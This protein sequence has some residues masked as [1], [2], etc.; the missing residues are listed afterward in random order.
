MGSA[1][2]VQCREAL[3]EQLRVLADVVRPMDADAATSLDALT[4]SPNLSTDV[5]ISNV[6]NCLVAE[7]T[8][9]SSSPRKRKTPTIDAARKRRKRKAV[10]TPREEVLSKHFSSFSLSENKIYRLVLLAKKWESQRAPILQFVECEAPR[11]KEDHS[12][13]WGGFTHPAITSTTAT[14]VNHLI[15]EIEELET[16]TPVRRRLFLVVVNELVES[17]ISILREKRDQLRKIEEELCEPQEGDEYRALSERV[18]ELQYQL[19]P[20]EGQALRTGVIQ[21]LQRGLWDIELSAEDRKKK[22]TKFADCVRW[23]KKYSQLHPMG[24]IFFL[25]DMHERTE[26]SDQEYQAVTSYWM[27]LTSIYELC[28]SY[29]PLAHTLKQG[30]WDSATNAAVANGASDHTETLPIQLRA[31]AG[32]PCHANTSPDADTAIEI[33][34]TVARTPQESY[35]AQNSAESGLQLAIHLTGQANS[36]PPRPQAPTIRGLNEN[37]TFSFPQHQEGNSQVQELNAGNQ[38]MNSQSSEVQASGSEP[39]QLPESDADIYDMI[40]HMLEAQASGSERVLFPERDSNTYGTFPMGNG[41]W[42][43]QSSEAQ[44]SCSEPARLPESDADI[45]DMIPFIQASGSEPAQLPESDADIYDMIPFIQASGS[46]D[47]LSY[48]LFI[49]EQGTSSEARDELRGAGKWF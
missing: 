33:P 25:G 35:H 28:V 11:W 32:S 38:E 3:R 7:E 45:Y 1:S 47:Y 12:L 24:I 34:A 40:P 36:F 29:T 46:A 49:E 16:L 2:S 5:A 43:S 13:F 41:G 26:W 20:Y 15:H 9:D 37:D 23:G 42:N 44:A 21:G 27:Q 30:Y 22:E 48:D 18:T 10:I 39:A 6:R 19:K 31:A 8:S 14:K 4:K 17:E